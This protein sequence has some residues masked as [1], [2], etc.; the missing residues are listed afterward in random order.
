MALLAVLLTAGAVSC[1]S[2]SH[3][4]GKDGSNTA[5]GRAL[6]AVPASL[7]TESVMFRDVPTNRRLV[8]KNRKLYSG[9]SG[10]GI[11]ELGL[12][13]AV[14]LK[15][16][17]GF[18]EKHVD[19][20]LIVGNTPTSVLTGTFDPDAISHVMTTKHKGYQAA[21]DDAGVHLKMAGAPTVDVSRS[22][23]IERG[24]SA[25]AV[26]LTPPAKSV[27]HDPAYR[28]VADCLGDTYEATLFGKHAGSNK[29]VVLLGVGG[30]VGAKDSSAETLCAVTASRAAADATA[31]ALRDKE[32]APGRTYAGA[33]VTVGDGD[34]PVVSMTWQNKPVSGLHP[35]DSDKSLELANLL[36]K[37]F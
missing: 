24:S 35:G 21:K 16:D 5:F 29:D 27:A 23:R 1:G 37:L 33:K 25:P 17:Y 15:D 9:L 20:S 28:A 13:A 2:D 36:L 32:T 30:R 6:A 22:V 26:P 8:A 11:P 31:K 7:A 10:Y 14:S 3:D 12:Y 4:G 34:L 19:T 18:D